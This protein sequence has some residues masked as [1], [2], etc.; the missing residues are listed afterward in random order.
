MIEKAKEALDVGIVVGN[1]DA[2]RRFYGEILG[3]PYVGALPV[4]G[5]EVHIYTFGETLLKLYAMNGVEQLPVPPFGSRPGLAYITM[6]ITKLEATF[7]LLK[8]KGATVIAPPGI[9]DGGATLPPPVGRMH[10]RYAL[11]GDADG[12]M[13]ELFEYLPVGD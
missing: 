1:L 10:A 3:L 9:F 5:G 11:I 7:E 2:Q 8:D 12:N 6:T 4:P 13:I